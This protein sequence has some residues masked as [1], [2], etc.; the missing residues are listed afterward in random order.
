MFSFSK[1]PKAKYYTIPQIDLS[2]KTEGISSRFDYLYENTVVDN[3]KGYLGHPD[4]VLLH[5]GTILTF[6]PEGH[7]K[8]RIISKKSIDGGKSYIDALLNAPTSWG[9]SLETPTVFRLEFRDGSEKLILISGNP[10]W[11]N[12]P[13]PL[14]FNCSI[15]DDDGETWSE[16][17][18]FYDKDSDFPVCPI[19]SMGSLIRLKENGEFTDKWMGIFHD[20]KFINYKTILTFKNGKMNWSKPESYLKEYRKIEKQTGVCEVCAIRSDMG[21]GDTICLIARA[22]KKRSNSVLFVSNDEGETWSNPKFLPTSLTGERHKAVY[23]PD[24]RLYITFRSIILDKEEVKKN[25]P[26]GGE[27][28]WY[29]EGLVAWV[30]TFDDII[31]LKEGEYRIKL[32]HTYLPKQNEPSIVANADTGYCGNVVL[33]DG[34]VVTSSYGIFFTDEKESGTYKTDKG[35]QKRKTCVVSKRVNV[36]DTDQLLKDILG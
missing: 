1:F 25:R 30:G 16:F 8:G 26:L 35:N 23:L 2:K 14:G 36:K 9:A 15:S 34:T 22:N 28:K 10:K 24:S 32:A 31:N 3:S 29:S 13:T 7:G 33:P 5:N 17:Q 4:S 6:Y 20:R 11:P 27:L 21:K 19:V 12:T 18:R